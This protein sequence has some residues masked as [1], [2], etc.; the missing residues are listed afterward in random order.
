MKGNSYRVTGGCG[1]GPLDQ[2][3]L[4]TQAVTPLKCTRIKTEAQ[5]QWDS[6]RPGTV[7]MLTR[8]GCCGTC[9]ARVVSAEGLSALS[10][11]LPVPIVLQQTQLLFLSPM[12][13]CCVGGLT[14]AGH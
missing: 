11:E 8:E 6:E 9:N 3:E 10:D 12:L 2:G 4:L 14:A 13:P 5:E 7:A 1:E